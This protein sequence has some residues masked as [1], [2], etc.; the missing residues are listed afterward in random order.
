M[1]EIVSR[2]AQKA[3]GLGKLAEALGIRHQSF[4]SWKKVPAER[5]PAFSAATGIPRHEIRPDLYPS[6][7]TDADPAGGLSCPSAAAG[8][9]AMEAAE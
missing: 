7:A 8:S 1:I 9:D 6:Q 3:G 2:A 4:Y 5:V